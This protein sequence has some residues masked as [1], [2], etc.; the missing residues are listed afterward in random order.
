MPEKPK[1]NTAAAIGVLALA[2]AGVALLLMSKKEGG[3]PPV[4]PPYEIPGC[5]LECA[6]NYNPDATLDDGSCVALVGCVCPEGF[7]KEGVSCVPNVEGDIPGCMNKDSPY[8]NPLATVDDGSCGTGTQNMVNLK[9][10]VIHHGSAGEVTFR[11]KGMAGDTPVERVQTTIALETVFNVLE[12]LYNLEME[13]TDLVGPDGLPFWQFLWTG[14]L[15][16]LADGGICPVGTISSPERCSIDID[17]YPPEVTTELTIRIEELMLNTPISGAVVQIQKAGSAMIEATTNASGTII[18]DNLPSGLYSIFVHAVPYADYLV[19]YDV[20]G[21][22]MSINIGLSLPTCD[23]GFHLGADMVTCET[24][25][26]G[27]KWNTIECLPDSTCATGSQ[28]EDAAQACVPDIAEGGIGTLTLTVRDVASNATLS[29]VTVSLRKG[30]WNTQG[31]M[32]SGY[33]DYPA[34]NDITGV[35]G[36][37]GYFIFGS[38]ATGMYEIRLTKAGYYLDMPYNIYK[39]PFTG[40]DYQTGYLTA[41]NTSLCRP[42]QAPAGICLEFYE[43]LSGSVIDTCIDYYLPKTKEQIGKYLLDLKADG[44]INQAQYDS[45]LSQMAGWCAIGWTGTAYCT[46][47]NLYQDYINSYCAFEAGKLKEANS[48]LCDTTIR[49]NQNVRVRDTNGKDIVGASVRIVNKGTG[50]EWTQVTAMKTVLTNMGAFA[51]FA[52]I[53]VGNYDVFVNTVQQ[54]WGQ[55]WDYAANSVQIRN[56][57]V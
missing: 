3:Q 45:A 36:A 52:L 34:G 47:V 15:W 18:I 25:P 49:F 46:G 19:D 30:I 40:T 23:P 37:G 24:C 8:Y 2:G 38:L 12:G 14:S 16:G 17:I 43:Q 57:Y 31:G 26:P 7:H 32:G 48:P 27:T 55:S 51:S 10:R 39:Y 6:V 4:Y 44:N 9:V 13:R 41:I 33:Y 1:S 21:E 20:T 54:I 28:W 53:P 56:I 42:Y 22:T 35:T 5:T 11:L 29:G 50:E